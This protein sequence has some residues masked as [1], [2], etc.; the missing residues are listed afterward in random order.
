MARPSTGWSTS[1]TSNTG[2]D[3]GPGRASTLSLSGRPS[4]NL[5]FSHP[6]LGCGPGPNCNPAARAGMVT[7]GLG[8]KVRVGE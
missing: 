8:L 4:R 6:G 7:P 5:Y 2:P 3:K 1:P